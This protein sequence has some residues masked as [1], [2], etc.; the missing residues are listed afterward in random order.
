ML[1]AKFAEAFQAA[2][3]GQDVKPELDKAAKDTDRELQRFKNKKERSDDV[4]PFHI[5]LHGKEK[6]ME[7]ITQKQT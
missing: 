3:L 4:T 6:R 5:F 1:S 7:P 2:A